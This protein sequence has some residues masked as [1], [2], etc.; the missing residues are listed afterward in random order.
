MDLIESVSEGFL[1]TLAILHSF[2]Q[3]IRT[4]EGDNEGLCSISKDVSSPS[5]TPGDFITGFLYFLY[6]VNHKPVK[7]PWDF[8]VGRLTTEHELVV[9]GFLMYVF[10]LSVID[11]SFVI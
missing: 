7:L 5:T 4:M 6:M 10:A 11:I 8:I 1:P 3:Y 9:L 2:Q